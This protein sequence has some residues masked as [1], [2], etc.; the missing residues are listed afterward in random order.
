M[1]DKHSQDLVV[2]WWSFALKA[3]KDIKNLKKVNDEKDSPSFR[4][5]RPFV[6]FPKVRFN[7]PGSSARAASRLYNLDSSNRMSS[8]THGNFQ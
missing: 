4:R 7:R 2:V 3:E 6:S 5:L 1:P 8:A